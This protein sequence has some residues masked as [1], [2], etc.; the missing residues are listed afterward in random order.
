MVSIKKIIVYVLLIIG[1]LATILDNVFYKTPI[2]WEGVGAGAFIM[3]CGILCL[4]FRKKIDR[5]VIIH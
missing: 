4:I 3:L 2:F 5:W 1:G